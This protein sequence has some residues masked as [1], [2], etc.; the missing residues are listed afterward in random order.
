MVVQGRREEQECSSKSSL[1][2][3]G[4]VCVFY[5]GKHFRTFIMLA[6]RCHR[7]KKEDIIKH[8]QVRIIDGVR[9]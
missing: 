7:R 5:N 9:P 6:G 3:R 2:T 1:V 8:S 4:G